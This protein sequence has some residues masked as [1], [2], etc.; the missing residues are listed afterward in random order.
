MAEG[1]PFRLGLGCSFQ[2]GETKGGLAA[3]GEK[4]GENSSE[5]KDLRK[6]EGSDKNDT[7]AMTKEK[8]QKTQKASTQAIPSRYQAA[9]PR[10]RD[11]VHTC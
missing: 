1:Q 2:E 9:P 5:P 8:E 4:P 7:A 3:P 10:H 6:P 11:A